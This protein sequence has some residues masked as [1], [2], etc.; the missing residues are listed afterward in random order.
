[1]TPLFGS[2]ELPLTC[3]RVTK[4]YR[5]RAWPMAIGL[6]VADQRL[7]KGPVPRVLLYN[8]VVIVPGRD[9]GPVTQ[10]TVA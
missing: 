1:M 3:R 6:E 8:C 2:H 9:E 4:Q 7:L 10:G 5:Y